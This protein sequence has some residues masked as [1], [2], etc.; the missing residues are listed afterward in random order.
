MTRPTSFSL[1]LIGSGGA[2]AISAGQLL[3][4]AVAHSG[5]HAVMT[6]AFGPQ[7]RGG[8]AAALLR[9]SDHPVECQA[10][11]LDLL[12][13]LDWEKSDRLAEDLAVDQSTV[14]LA[15]PETGA[16]PAWIEKAGARI[17]PLSWSELAQGNRKTRPNMLA[18]GVVAAV[19]GLGPQ[20]M[21]AAAQRQFGAK[22]AAVVQTASAAIELGR[23]FAPHMD[24]LIPQVENESGGERWQITGNQASALGAVLGGVRFCAAYPITP[25][26]EILEWLAGR[27][28]AVGGCLVQAEDELASINMC[29]GASFGGVPALTATS[30]PG[31]ALMVETLGLAVATE[32]PVVVVNVM[33]GGPSTGIP[34]RPEQSDLNIAIH[35]LHGDAPH[36][37]IAPNGIVDCLI[38]TRQA[39]VLAESLQTP[40]LVLSD[41]GLGQT[42]AVIEAP[43]TEEGKRFGELKGKRRLWCGEGDGDAYQRYRD[44]ADGVAPMALP[45]SLGGEHTVT[46]LSHDRQ[47]RPTTRSEEHRRQLDKRQRK[48]ESF[49]PGEDWAT[50]E[51]DGAMALITFGSATAPAREGLALLAAEGIACRMI[52]VRLLSPLNVAGLEQALSGVDRALILELNHQGQ[53]HRHLR[54]HCRLPAHTTALHRPGPQPFRPAEIVDAIRKLT[55]ES[56]A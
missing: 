8:E 3:L 49:D 48:L 15:D 22:G 45:G 31:L 46:G 26:T 43:A 33:R 54:A 6:R 56:A 18:C 23:Q 16:I 52:S 55:M 20:T 12:I 47:G 11:R 35:G 19:L 5:L 40:V 34:T 4:A 30:G 36:P 44:S 2:G 32:V 51:G 27:L 1:A 7:I 10:E 41:Q 17:Q 28:P 50:I 53:F 29:L 9:L 21:T 42:E 38:A 13:A 24:R 37:V 39:V 25:A 14:V